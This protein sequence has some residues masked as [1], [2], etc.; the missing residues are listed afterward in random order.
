MIRRRRSGPIVVRRRRSAPVCL[1]MG[2]VSLVVVGC[3]GGER[4]HEPTSAAGEAEAL[5]V[6]DELMELP[7]VED[8]VPVYEAL[9]EEVRSATDAM[10][11]EGDW[12]VDPSAITTGMVCGAEY[13]DLDG[14]SVTVRSVAPDHPLED[15]EWNRAVENIADVVGSHG[16]GDPSVLV[17]KPGTHQ[18]V[19]TGARG[20]TV[21]VYSTSRFEVR[22]QSGCYLQDADREAISEFG[23]PDPE[24]WA[25]LYPG[26]TQITSS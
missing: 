23:V 22:L 25:R 14:R 6:I 3:G 15:E 9:G 16:F 20:A 24:E 26:S 19:F 1:A 11:G 17:D 4:P 7:S 2:L 13:S 10:V 12:V 8:L 21:S 18:V 5:A